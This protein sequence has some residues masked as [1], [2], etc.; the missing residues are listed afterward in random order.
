MAPSPS[1]S[2]QHPRIGRSWRRWRYP[3][4]ALA[5]SAVL[6]VSPL[7]VQAVADDRVPSADP[8][9]EATADPTTTSEPTPSTDPTSEPSSSSEPSTSPDPETPASE[10]P[11]EQAS[12]PGPSD[13]ADEPSDEPSDEPADAGSASTDDPGAPTKHGRPGGQDLFATG[14]SGTYKGSIDWFEWGTDGAAIPPQG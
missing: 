10:T 1:Q 7:N 2:L 4:V 13:A 6:V 14:G 5:V 11:A 8:T 9:A 3:V 12:D